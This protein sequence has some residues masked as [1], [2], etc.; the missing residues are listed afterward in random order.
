MRPLLL[1]GFCLFSLPCVAQ[2]PGSCMPGSANGRLD[3]SGVDVRVLTAGRIG[4]GAG[5]VNGNGYVVPKGSGHSPLFIATLQIGGVVEGEVRATSSSTSRSELWPGPLDPAAALPF[6]TDCSAYDRVW[7]VSRADV[8]A[9]ES[10]QAATDDLAEWPVGLGAPTVDAR[11][12]PV[13]RFARNQRIDLAAGERPVVSGTQMAF[14]VMNDVGN[15]H[16][17]T[18]TTPLGIEVRA[19]ASVVAS[20]DPAFDQATFY[21]FEI[22]NRNSRP[23]EWAYAGLFA[24]P[25][26]GE[27]RD[28]QGATDTTRAMAYVYNAR[29]R[30]A[31]YGVPPAFGI[32]LL[33]GLNAATI[34]NNGGREA[35]LPPVR[36]A[37][38]YD[39]FQGLWNDGLPIREG[40]DGYGGTGAVTRFSYPG[41]PVTRQFWSN[42]NSGDPA[43]EAGGGVAMNVAGPIFRLDP[44]A[45]HVFN[46]AFLFAQGTD[47]LDSVVRL[48]AASDAVQA[49][50]DAGALFPVAGETTPTPAEALTLGAPH[51][52]PAHGMVRLGV[53]A[54]GPSRLRLVDVLGR[55]VADE[56]LEAGTREARLDVRGLAPGVYAAVLDG[57]EG[58]AVRTLTVVR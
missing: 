15:V 24:D 50:Y 20:P 54:T 32:D 27:S 29:E 21:R 5:F 35:T 1:A 23:I 38:V 39:R 41:D 55:T 34:A 31:V 45:S 28:D 7:V 9:Y 56:R 58:R 14:W 17:G 2:T 18:Q 42:E 26:L 49:A 33:D 53:T 4:F 36:G 12:R 37:D 46:A 25:D 40:G 22:V 30:D 6:P 44:G 13:R 11:G 52:N 51:P 10:G 16:L 57:G 19:T 48:R 43:T 8:S 47:R 3:A